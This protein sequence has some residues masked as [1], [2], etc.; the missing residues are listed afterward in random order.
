MSEQGPDTGKAMEETEVV[1]E[2][3][4]VKETVIVEPVPD[5]DGE[6]IQLPERDSSVM[7]AWSEAKHGV[8][9]AHEVAFSDIM[10]RIF[11]ALRGAY[12]QGMTP[13]ELRKRSGVKKKKFRK[14]EE[15]DMDARLGD[16]MKV[17]NAA[18]MTLVVMPQ[19]EAEQWYSAQEQQESK[20]AA[21]PECGENPEA[22]QE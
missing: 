9:T 10:S 21:A 4:T 11:A 1:S 20:A 5:E 16:V 6:V 19:A 17:L 18:G 2:A 13:K 15:M 14:I 22:P 8:F 7:A 12:E 3:E